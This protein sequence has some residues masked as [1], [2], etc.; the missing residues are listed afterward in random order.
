MKISPHN[1]LEFIKNIPKNIVSCLLY[2]PD[3]GLI[4]ERKKYIERYFLSRNPSL[5]IKNFSYD[6]IKKDFSVVKEFFANLDLF[7]SEQVAVID[8]VPV[9][10]PLDL[11]KI[12]KSLTTGKFLLLIAAELKPN[13]H[14]RLLYEN[15]NN[16]A[17]LACYYDDEKNVKSIIANIFHTNKIQIKDDEISLLASLVKG[18]RKN[19]IN[20]ANK[21]VTY[22]L[23][24]NQDVDI[25]T[26]NELC[27]QGFDSSFDDLV[28]ALSNFN[29]DKVEF[30]V[31]D[32]LSNGS[33]IVTVVRK[34]TNHFIRIYKVK[35]IVNEGKSYQAAIKELSPPVFIMQVSQFIK[36][37]EKLSLTQIRKIIYHLYNIELC[38]KTEANI[39]KLSFK[40]LLSKITYDS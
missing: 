9:K 4:Y 25:R 6:E 1:H 20:E 36:F 23:G 37:A 26:L 38:C 8:D 17:S 33:N 15:N 27:S 32:L 19:I 21:V 28:Q 40:F 12:I 16:F 35:L 29:Y 39:G 3:N 2:G 5:I 24:S 34:L 30:I 14:T 13:S 10:I 18:D 11:E 7:S 31:A 22:Y